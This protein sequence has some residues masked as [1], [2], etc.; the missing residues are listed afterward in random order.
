MSAA[1]DI[2]DAL[3]DRL[4]LVQF[5]QVHRRPT[6][7]I[8][9]PAAI[10][11]RGAWNPTVDVDLSTDLTFGVL[12]CTQL[13]T[14]DDGT[15][16]A[17]DYAEEAVDALRGDQTLGGVARRV[18]IPQVSGEAIRDIGGTPYATCEITVEVGA[19]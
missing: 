19:A 5:A 2:R 16:D 7:T 4:E 8:T 13:G 10:I 14:W 9:P 1:T 15:R 6:T 17:D 11:L 3:G 18:V 12:I